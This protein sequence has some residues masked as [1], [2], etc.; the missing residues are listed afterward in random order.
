[1]MMTC[2]E[3]YGFL[4]EFLDGVLDLLTRQSFERHLERCASCRKYLASYRT[5]LSVARSTLIGIV[6][7]LASR[8][9]VCT[10]EPATAHRTPANISASAPL[11]RP[12]EEQAIPSGLALKTSATRQS[13]PPGRSS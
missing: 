11:Q 13:A 9:C 6:C 3:L 7:S 10:Q 2:R 4:D 1:M 5:T 8:L 12:I